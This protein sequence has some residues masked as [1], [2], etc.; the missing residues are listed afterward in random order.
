[1]GR[2]CHPP[3]SGNAVVV[4]VVCFVILSIMPVFLSFNFHSFLFILI[5]RS[6]RAAPIKCGRVESL[7]VFPTYSIRV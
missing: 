3:P 4:D 5:V 2:R 7:T 1:M 6:Q